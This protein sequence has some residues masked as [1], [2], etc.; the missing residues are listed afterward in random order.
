MFSYSREKETKAL[1]MR[2]GGITPDGG[3]IA[4]PFP[5][6]FLPLDRISFAN[7]IIYE[8]GDSE[9]KQE[10]LD[11]LMRHLF[12]IYQD[13]RKAGFYSCPDLAGIK[14]YRLT[15]DWTDVP[16]ERSEHTDKLVYSL[17]N[18]ESQHYK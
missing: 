7:N 8:F 10:S 11:I 13:N 16:A 12:S 17:I 4:L 6:C 18:G 15:W 2:L 1:W 9:E 14:V 5:K 3:E